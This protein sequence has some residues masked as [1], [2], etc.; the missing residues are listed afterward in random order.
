[1]WDWNAGLL[2]RVTSGVLIV[3]DN[4]TT[5]SAVANA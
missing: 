4:E 5:V 2:P 3:F 1:M